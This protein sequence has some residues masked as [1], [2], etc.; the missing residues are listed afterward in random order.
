MNG[1]IVLVRLSH[2][3]G[4]FEWIKEKEEILEIMKEWMCSELMMLQ[5]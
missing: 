4:S 2:R 5:L 3:K 1:I